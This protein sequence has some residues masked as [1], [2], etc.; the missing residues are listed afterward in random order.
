MSILFQREEA[1]LIRL[2]IYFIRF[3]EQLRLQWLRMVAFNLVSFSI[4]IPTSL[5]TETY[6]PLTS[7]KCM[8]ALSKR[9]YTTMNVTSTRFECLQLKRI[10]SGFGTY[11]IIPS[12]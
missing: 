5:W 4:F 10:A 1:L 2:D 7:T 11:K 3:I 8:F 6:I 9:R 12:Y